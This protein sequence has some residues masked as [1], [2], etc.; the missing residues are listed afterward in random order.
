MNVHP[1]WRI[2]VKFLSIIWSVIYVHECDEMPVDKYRKKE[3]PIPDNDFSLL[4][5]SSLIYF[6]L[7]MFIVV[8][9]HSPYVPRHTLARTHAHTHSKTFEN[10]NTTSI[11]TITTA[12]TRTKIDTHTHTPAQWVSE[13]EWAQKLKK[14]TKTTTAITIEAQNSIY[15]KSACVVNVNCTMEI[16]WWNKIWCSISILVFCCCACFLHVADWERGKRVWVKVYNN[17]VWLKQ[18]NRPNWLWRTRIH[19][20]QRWDRMKCRERVER[21]RDR[22]QSGWLR[23]LQTSQQAIIEGNR[24]A[25]ERKWGASW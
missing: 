23:R 4:L 1:F 3:C 10:T 5:A 11:I 6:S 19:N 15:G 21:A 22:T 14:S 8:F 20:Q 18:R 24:R 2:I 25:N 7:T 12:T 17:M 13:M 16:N 9:L